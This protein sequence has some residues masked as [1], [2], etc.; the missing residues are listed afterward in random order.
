MAELK[1]TPLRHRMLTEIG[2][3]AIIE[4]DCVNLKQALWKPRR[5]T[6]GQFNMSAGESRAVGDLLF[7]YANT[8]YWQGDMDV[9]R[10]VELTPAGRELLSE[11]NEK[12]GKVEL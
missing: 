2:S 3:G 9:L 5:R 4:L 10:R 7:T 6:T 11:W 12:H 8:P 1:H